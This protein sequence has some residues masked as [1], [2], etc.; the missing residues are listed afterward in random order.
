[1]PFLKEYRLRKE[2]GRNARHEAQTGWKDEVQVGSVM[3]KI[4][5]VEGDRR[6]AELIRLYLVSE[7][8]TVQVAHD[9]AEGLDLAQTGAQDLILLD[10]TLPS[11]SGLDIIRILRSQTSVPVIVLGA[12]STER[13]KLLSLDLGADDYITKPVSLRE[14]GARVGAVLRRAGIE[15]IPLTLFPEGSGNL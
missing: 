6:I 10:L 13:D 2:S 14:L 12:A 11:I 5:L 3:S 9:G 4:L 7:R 1:L 8:Y 15:P